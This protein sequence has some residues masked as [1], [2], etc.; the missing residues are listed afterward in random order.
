MAIWGEGGCRF[1]FAKEGRNMYDVH[2]Y[3]RCVRACMFYCSARDC[4]LVRA[5]YQV[6]LV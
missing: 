3:V 4:V 5:M 1:V 2:Q 6:P